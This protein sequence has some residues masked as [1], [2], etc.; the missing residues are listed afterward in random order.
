MCCYRSKPFAWSRCGGPPGS[1]MN[2]RSTI[3]PGT[4]SRW[5]ACCRRPWMSRLPTAVDSAA[6]PLVPM[7]DDRMYSG[8]LGDG[9]RQADQQ[10]LCW[11]FRQVDREEKRRRTGG[12]RE[13]DRRFLMGDVAHQRS[14]C[15]CRARRPYEKMK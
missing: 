9:S 6:G 15:E 5:D 7:R 11:R 8:K 1:F 10:N 4:A 13:E 14:T 3:R 12:D 2:A